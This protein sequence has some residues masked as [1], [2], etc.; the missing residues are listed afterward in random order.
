MERVEQYYILQL[1]PEF[2]RWRAASRHSLE[3]GE[4]RGVTWKERVKLR[5]GQLSVV[6]RCSRKSNTFWR[7]TYASAL[8]SVRCEIWDKTLASADF[9]I[10]KMGLVGAPTCLPGHSCVSSGFL[11]SPLYLETCCS[12]H[13]TPEMLAITLCSF[14]G[15]PERQK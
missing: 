15:F 4:A 9:L 10:C 8:P 11:V 5:D 2:C 13:L 12:V 7:R 14:Q 3:K 6:L 1:A